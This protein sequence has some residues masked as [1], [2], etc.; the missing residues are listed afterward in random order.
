MGSTAVKG[1][2]LSLSKDEGWPQALRLLQPAG[3]ERAAVLR[4][5]SQLQSERTHCK[6]EAAVADLQL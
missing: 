2:V 6:D 5:A 1:R 3:S 4:D